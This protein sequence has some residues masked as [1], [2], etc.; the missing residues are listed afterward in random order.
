[1]H[2]SLERVLTYVRVYLITLTNQISRLENDPIRLLRVPYVSEQGSKRQLN[3]IKLITHTAA[4]NKTDV[5]SRH[6]MYYSPSLYYIRQLLSLRYF[7]ILCPFYLLQCAY[8]T[9]YLKTIFEYSHLDW[10]GT[11]VVVGCIIQYA[12]L[13]MDYNRTTGFLH[14]VV[15][16]LLGHRLF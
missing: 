8:R 4:V 13:G 6:W 11:D 14:L 9:Y 2:T 12:Q 16:R 5:L 7:T 15:A 1:M 10:L 3:N